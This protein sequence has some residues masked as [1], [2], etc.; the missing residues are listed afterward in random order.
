MSTYVGKRTGNLP[1]RSPISCGGHKATAPDGTAALP[2]GTRRILPPGFNAKPRLIP[3]ASPKERLSP[4]NEPTAFG[5]EQALS[6]G[7]APVPTLKRV[8]E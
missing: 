5:G 2:P 4:W 8:L 7:Q 6:A 3:S 1:Q